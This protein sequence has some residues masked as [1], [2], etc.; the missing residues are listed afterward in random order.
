MGKIGKGG[1]YSLALKTSIG[2]LSCL[3]A[4]IILVCV[5][6]MNYWLDGTFD[7]AILGRSFEQTETFLDDV[8]MTIRQKISCTRNE[9][10]FE[11]AGETDLDKQIDVHQ[12]ASG[13]DD[14]ANR[15]ENTTY[16]L[17]DL[18]NFYPQTGK[19]RS[20]LEE[21]L[22]STDVS[23]ATWE[24]LSHR[25]GDLE[26][27]LPSS[28][29]TLA[30]TATLAQNP[31]TT[32]EGYYED[33]CSCSVDI[34]ARYQSY[35]SELK[36]P[37]GEAHANAPSN[38][39]Y[40][41][42]DTSNKRYYT[43]MDC[44]TCSE[45]RNLIR[46]HRNLI[47]LF[48]GVRSL[49]IMVANSDNTLNTEV[50]ERFIDTVFS[51]SNERVIIAVTRGYPAGDSLRE[52]FRSYE[53]REPVVLGSFVIGIIS[54]ILLL[55]L[56]CLGLI[57]AGRSSMGELIPLGRMDS[58]P[59][60]LEG[61][62]YLIIMILSSYGVR[63]LRVRTT[64][65]LAE[66]WVVIYGVLEYLIVYLALLS[67]ARRIKWKSFWQNSV[68]YTVWNVS[69]KIMDAKVT[70]QRLLVFYFAFILC[71]I[72]AVR[73]FHAAGMVIAVVMDLGLLLYLMRDQIGKLSVREGLREI[74]KGKL[75]YKIDRKGLTGDSLEMAIAV[76]EMGDGL[77]EA[78]ES[79]IKS[80]RLRA[81]LIT[82]VSHDLKT[83]LTS[84]INYV[85]LLK[86][87]DLR[88]EKARE[89]IDVL[90]HK[91]QRLKSLVSDLIDASRIS[92][93]NI[94]L[95]MVR[96]DLRQMVQMAEGEFEERFEDK[97]LSVDMRLKKERI[98]VNADGSQLFRVFDNLLSNIAKYARPGS[99]VRITLEEKEGLASAI[100][101]NESQEEMTKSG[102]ELE[103]RFVRG[104]LSRGSEGSGLGLSI[105]KSL[106]ELMNG[107]FQ[108]QTAGNIFY[109]AVSF[110]ALPPE[111]PAPASES[112]EISENPEDP[113]KADSFERPEDPEDPGDSES[114]TDLGDAGVSGKLEE[115]EDA[116]IFG[117]PKETEGIGLSGNPE[118]EEPDSPVFER[119]GHPDGFM[120]HEDK[121]SDTFDT[122][123]D[124]YGSSE[125]AENQKTDA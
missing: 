120:S 39:S 54:L 44:K 5:M 115:P 50:A 42:E 23:D 58:L 70:T 12:Y 92:S 19:L 10:L 29:K 65:Q 21:I 56:L 15:N 78:V 34:Y 116:G 59:V 8:E 82:N 86:R 103:E 64:A 100:F 60:E 61:G 89:Y 102:D 33:L 1:R 95:E 91:S 74:S 51:G 57:T 3:S 28:G 48:E 35:V 43:N 90:D 72:V 63:E 16:T 85:D 80:E 13:V 83:P 6:T 20:I 123:N 124:S 76:N 7:M 49:S 22:A 81:E 94:D 110:P 97:D 37:T 122:S 119:I 68:T 27:I 18:I 4:A 77:Q 24:N 101:V 111:E 96:L 45:A 17:S 98:F 105:A 108:I 66:T 113:E 47:F 53:R 73:F 84:I 52:D 75:D 112:S 88:D 41:V 99:T 107:S 67:M 36:N 71:N 55:L 118:A 32:L 114:P 79:M 117:S 26:T 46:K 38:V 14:A 11:T 121:E 9:I 30:E 31:F 62:I 106:T 93:G 87:L 40:F 125:T 109:A 104:D 25:T 2:A 69:S